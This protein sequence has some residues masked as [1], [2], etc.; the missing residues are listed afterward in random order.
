MKIPVLGWVMSLM[1]WFIKG[2]FGMSRH[3]IDS[4][5]LTFSSFRDRISVSDRLIKSNYMSLRKLSPRER[6]IFY[7]MAFLRRTNEAGFSREP[8]VTPDVFRQTVDSQLPTEASQE[9]NTLT[10]AFYIARYSNKHLDQGDV[11][12][13]VSAWRRLRE[14][15]RKLHKDG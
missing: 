1:V 13:A 15:L 3:F 9:T 10:E 11:I 2:V 12:P 8:Y 6:V 4:V 14:I 7:Y 5:N